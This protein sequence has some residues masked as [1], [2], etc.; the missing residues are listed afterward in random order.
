MKF[1]RTRALFVLFVLVLHSVC[2]AAHAS[3]TKTEEGGQTVT[4]PAATATPASRPLLIF[5]HNPKAGGGAI[6]LLLD[7][8]KP[9]MLN[10]KYNDPASIDTNTNMIGITEW[11]TVTSQDQQRGFVISNMREP[12]DQYLSLWAFGSTRRGHMYNTFDR[13]DHNWTM[14]AYGKDPPA[15]DSDRDIATFQND[16]LRNDKVRGLIAGRFHQSYGKSTPSVDCWVFVSD[17]GESLV[18][19]LRQFEDQGGSVNWTA[20]LLAG[21][22]KQLQDR[23]K[24][25]S[26]V[27]PSDPY[28]KNDPLNSH[29][30][31]HHS[32]CSTYYDEATA[33]F[34]REG[35]ESFIYDMFG[36]TGCCQPTRTKKHLS[37]NDDIAEEQDEDKIKVQSGEHDKEVVHAQTS[38][39]YSGIV[40]TTV[41]QSENHTEGGEG[42]S[43]IQS[44]QQVQNTSGF[45]T[46]R[47]PS[48]VGFSTGVITGASIV[49]V[50][51]GFIVLLLVRKVIQNTRELSR[52]YQPTPHNDDD[53][54][55]ERA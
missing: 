31:E 9:K 20:P 40:A 8:I 11:Q 10:H 5:K 7:E 26:E 32:K 36:Y 51:L 27:A 12:C 6:K 49:I 38:E 23:R 19:C 52:R 4:P 55:T 17:F 47:S 28:N 34:I 39:V 37:R 1:I 22:V 24:M 30:K 45:V 41:Q 42:P 35:E 25:K 13:K 3:T 33:T 44:G 14:K 46:N 48:G 2:T 54:D 15:F 21:V 43:E 29:Q 50:W 53:D 18:S 16:F